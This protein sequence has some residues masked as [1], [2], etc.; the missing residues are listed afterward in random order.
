[1]SGAPQLLRS[2]QTR[3][4]AS[5]HRHPLAGLMFRG[6][7]MDPTLFPRALHDA[8]LDQLDRDGRLVNGQHAGRLTRCGTDAAGKLGEIVGRMQAPNSVLPAA[9]V[10]QVV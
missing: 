5:Y 3:R 4:S 9:V 7:R 1:M 8:A 2:R 10:D 6:L